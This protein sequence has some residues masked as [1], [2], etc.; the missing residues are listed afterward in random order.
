M[1]KK[2]LKKVITSILV[3]AITAFV[4]ALLQGVLDYVN[5]TQI[6]LIGGAGASV[7]YIKQWITNPTG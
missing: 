4:T 2:T 3:G 1:D 7:Y 6:N 5:H